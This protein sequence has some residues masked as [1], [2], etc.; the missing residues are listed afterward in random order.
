MKIRTSDETLISALRI[1]ANDIVSG[2]GVANAAIAEAADRLQE[3]STPVITLMASEVAVGHCVIIDEVE[4]PC[5]SHVALIVSV[6]NDG[7]PVAKYLSDR[8]KYTS[9]NKRGVRCKGATPVS[10]FGIRLVVKGNK[11][12]A[13]SIGPS[14]ATYREGGTRYWQDKFPASE[15]ARIS[16][17]SKAKFDVS[18]PLSP[19]EQERSSEL[20]A[21]AGL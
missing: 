16:L 2:D 15:T 19:V 11:F 8:P 17:M 3:L 5:L 10:K 6:D 20:M 7:N 4:A 14:T 21:K 13:E 12:V 1:L 9:H 18:T